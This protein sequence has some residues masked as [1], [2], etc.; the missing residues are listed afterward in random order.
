[1]ADDGRDSG[2]NPADHL[3]PFRW[4]PGQSGNPGGRPKGRSVV[5]IL[6]ELLDA[7]ALFN[8]PIPGDRRLAD[9]FAESMY[10]HAIMGGNHHFAKEILDRLYGKLAP[11]TTAERVAAAEDAQEGMSPNDDLVDDEDIDP[12]RAEAMLRAGLRDDEHDPP[13][14]RGG[15]EHEAGDKAPPL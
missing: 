4:R 7:E 1:M 15:E 2:R 14:A 12:D 5:A 10:W 8:R 13:P 11:E 6:R 9:F 3:I